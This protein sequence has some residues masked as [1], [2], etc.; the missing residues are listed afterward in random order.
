[1]RNQ[2]LLFRMWGS[3]FEV[4]ELEF[5]VQSSGGRV[6][7]VTS[8]RFSIVRI[9]DLSCRVQSVECIVHAPWHVGAP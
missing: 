5:G 7:S 3:R 4:C 1:M 6:Q 9:V 8:E 2:G